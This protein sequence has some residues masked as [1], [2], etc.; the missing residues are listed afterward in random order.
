MRPV[1]KSDLTGRAR[2]RETALELFAERGFEAT[3]TRAVAAAAGLSPALV[4]RHFG[5]KQGLREAVDTYVL[6]RITEQLR[7][8]APAADLMAALGSASANVF[9]ADPILRGYLRHVL[10]EDSEASAELFGRLLAGARAEV[11]RLTAAHKTGHSEGPDG[12]W[13]AFQMLC[14]ILGPLLLE[15]VMQPQLDEPM[16][17]PDVLARR[18]A[19]NQQLLLRGYY[20]HLERGNGG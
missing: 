17:A 10:M 14:L 7:E 15:R 20:G 18:S 4:T 2:L 19:A 12:E 3:S 11:E 13:A 1:A 16:F 9:G 5:S 6:E 8:L